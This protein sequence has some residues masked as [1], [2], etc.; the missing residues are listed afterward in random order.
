MSHLGLSVTDLDRSVEFYCDVLG[1]LMVRP[2]FAGTSPSF[3]GRMAIVLLGS[4]ALDLYE[5]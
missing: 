2:P 4:M 5:H 3:S 1:G